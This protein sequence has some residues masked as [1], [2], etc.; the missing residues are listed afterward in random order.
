[1]VSQDLVKA[2]QIYIWISFVLILLMPEMLSA[3]DKKIGLVLSGGGAKGIAHIGVLKALE[4]AGIRPDYIT[5]T[6]MGAVVGGLYSIGYSADQIEEIV[7]EIDWNQILSNQVPL[8]YISF[9]E[10]EY[11]NRYLVEFPFEGL[12]LKLPSGLIEGQVLTETL[13]HYCWPANQFE[14]FDQFPIPFRCMATDVATAES[15]VMKDGSLAMAIRSS[16]ALPSAFT[17]VPYKNTLLVD[18]GVLNNFPVEEVKKM[19]AEFVIGVNVSTGIDN[20]EMPESML[21]ILVNLAT[22]AADK[23]VYDQI[24][25][26]DIYIQPNLGPYSTGSFSDYEAILKIGDETGV[27]FFDELVE[28]SAQL[29]RDYNHPQVPKLEKVKISG[30]NLEGNRLFSDKLVQSKLGISRDSVVDRN[31]LENSVRR[32]FSINGFNKVNYQLIPSGRGSYKLDL[33][34]HEKNRTRLFG[35]V[36]VDNQ[37]AAGVVLNLTTRD[38]LGKE[39]RT[40]I[41]GDISKT[42]AFRFDYY[43]YFGLEK[44]L[45]LN[46]RYDYVSDELAFYENGRETDIR[47]DNLHKIKLGFLTTQSLTQS[48]FG[49]LVFEYRTIKS[50]FGVAFP[51]EIE[52][53]RE[54]HLLGSIGYTFNT[55]NDR[56]FPTD[57]SEIYISVDGIFDNQFRILLQSEDEGLQEFID[58]VVK[59]LS[60]GFYSQVFVQAHS[61]RQLGEKTQIQ[62]FGA[63]GFTLASADTGLFIRPFLMGGY[64]RRFIEDIRAYGLNYAEIN[65]FNVGLLGVQLQHVVKDNIFIRAGGNAYSYYPFLAISKFNN[66]N[67]DDFEQNLGLGYGMELRIRTRLGPISGGLSTNTNDG[68]LRYYF[69]LGFSFNYSD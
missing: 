69:A 42:P 13:E 54:R 4:K 43:K 14:S 6:S 19:G 28:L 25:K 5:G 35:S 9:E 8:N 38:F 36:H 67:W 46:C 21:G 22:L 61:F 7:R 29:G 55:L 34:M 51:A 16:M 50:R 33:D 18:G 17:A 11:Y 10:K 20:T 15:V 41:A 48:F 56:N 2:N 39:S 37:F 63:L 23:R 64:Q 12:K 30:V 40:I 3:Q 26:C 45:A 66:F 49:G 58:E 65:E 68:Y 32:V 47:I 57:G 52:S 27:E 53:I 44:K 24:D 59:D 1:M 60:P 31:Q 62:P